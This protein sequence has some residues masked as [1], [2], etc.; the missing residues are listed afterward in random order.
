MLLM[1]LNDLVLPPDRQRVGDHMQGVLVGEVKPHRMEFRGLRRDGSIVQAEVSSSPM[2]VG[3]KP[4]LVFL[5]SDI[6]ARKHA[7]DEVR[8]LQARLHQQ[9]IHDPLTA[10]YNRRYLDETFDRELVRAERRS[11]PVAVVLGD[12]DLFKDANDKY[13]HLAGD[14]ILRTLGGLMR[15]SCRSSDIGYRYGGEEF[16]L[17]FPDMAVADARVRTEELRCKVEDVEIPFGTLR[18]SVTMSFGVAV[19]PDDGKTPDELIAAA[20]HA[21]YRAKDLGRNRVELAERS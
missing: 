18:L 13:G 5:I 6:T 15:R 21:L 16:L 4:A 11:Y 20:D 2:E 19:F 3:G 1:T 7:E 12:I 10:M 14:E 17:V 9:V 8:V